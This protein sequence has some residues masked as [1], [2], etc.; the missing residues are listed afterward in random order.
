[1]IYHWQ[2]SMAY[3]IKRGSKE[4]LSSLLSRVNVKMSTGGR[5]SPIK[6]RLQTAWVH[7]AF[8]LEDMET[9]TVAFVSVADDAHV[10]LFDAARLRTAVK[11]Q[12]IQPAYVLRSCS[13]H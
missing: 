3:K 6:I 12:D 4:E 13:K 7:G 10:E 1:M 5:S 11:G 2:W 8:C 9:P